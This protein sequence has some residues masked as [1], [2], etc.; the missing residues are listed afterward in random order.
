MGGHSKNE[1]KITIFLDLNQSSPHCALLKNMLKVQSLLEI[2]E[3]IKAFQS[4]NQTIG[5]VPTM[6]ALH[7]GHLALIERSK[8]ENDICVVSIFVNPLQFNNDEDFEKYPRIL[9]QDLQKLEKKGVSVVFFPSVGEFYSELP[10]IS[11]DFGFLERTLEGA[12]RPDHFRGV[13]LVLSRFF[14]LIKPTKAYFGLKDLQQYL[15]IRRLVKDLLFDIEVVGVETVREPSG[16]ALSSRNLR[17][18][19]TGK[20]MAANIFKGLML[21]KNG[22]NTEEAISGIK[23]EL[24][25]FYDGCAGLTLEYCEIVN[26][27]DLAIIE[28]GRTYQEI[29]VCVA[30]Y[31]EG[32]RLIDNLYLRFE[33]ARRC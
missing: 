26:G 21:A 2:K 7:E 31:V 15:I 22:L 33:K 3:D 12:H 28:K 18:S 4:R 25:G 29:A 30:G 23:S 5:F 16:L 32:V 27:E 11:I 10:T 9:D 8:A 24:L 14:H 1:P 6:G 19:D 20:D 13:G 17:L